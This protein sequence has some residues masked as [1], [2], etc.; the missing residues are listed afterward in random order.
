MKQSIFNGRNFLMEAYILLKYGKISKH[1]IESL[2]QSQLYFARPDTLNDPFDCQVDIVKSLKNATSKS[3][4]SERETLNRLLS[5]DDLLK[6]FKDAQE[7]I[8]NAGVYSSSLSN[9][10]FTG[11]GNSLMWSHY[12]DSHKGICLVYAMPE[13]FIADT[14][15]SFYGIASVDYTYDPLCELFRQLV[16]HNSDLPENP[17]IDVV[18][19]ALTV[20]DECWSPEK[21]MRILRKTAGKVSIDKSYLKRVYFGLNTPDNDIE[22]IRSILKGSNYTSVPCFKMERKS[23]S[24]FGIKALEMV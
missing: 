19:K 22:L 18:K 8:K 16:S 10:N 11:I 21:E 24:D 9:H 15:N 3:T 20:K 1:L 13:S 5:H 6:G 12:A 4:G 7:D 14:A 17:F 23:E 2:V